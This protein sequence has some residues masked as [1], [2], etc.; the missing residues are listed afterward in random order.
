VAKLGVA[1]TT[2]LIG[3]VS[4]P[5]AFVFRIN[6]DDPHP[7][8][9]I[10]AKLSCALGRALYPHPQWARLEALWDS[11]YPTA[12]LDEQRTRLIG[13]LEKTLPSFVALMVNHRPRA[14]R[15]S[16]LGEV[17]SVSE[18]Q[19]DR[20]TALYKLWKCSPRRMQSAAPTLAFAVVGQARADGQIS[21]E[22]ESQLLAGLLTY[23]ALRGTL[24]MSEL[25]ALQARA[26]IAAPRI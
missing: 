8:P 3:V 19:P 24:D 23:W 2:G 9:W 21:P 7:F 25:C 12:G 1:A 16:S 15:G 10:R 26:G 17:L 11:F 6:L 13:I 22:E 18:R 5:R 20:L 14:L 4:L